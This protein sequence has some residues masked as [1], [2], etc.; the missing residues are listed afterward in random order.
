[1]DGKRNR[2]PFRLSL[3]LVVLTIA[4]YWGVWAN[5]F[6][7]WDDQ[8]YVYENP[9]V[10]SGLSW[11]NFVWAWTTS[12]CSNWH[13]LTWLSLMLDASLFGRGPAGFHVTNLALH[14]ANVVLLF[15][16]LRQFTEEVRISACAAAMFAVHPGHVESVAWIS[17][18][19]DVLC[20]F[21]G[22]LALRAYGQFAEKLKLRFYFGSLTAFA[23]SLLAKPMLVTFPF[24][25]ILLDHWPLK[26]LLYVG[27]SDSTILPPNGSTTAVST[28]G[29][30]DNRRFPRLLAEK[31]PFFLLSALSCLIT[32]QVQQ[33]GG[34]VES[35]LALQFRLANAVIAYGNYV[36]CVLIPAD[37]SV[38][39]PHARTSISWLPLVGSLSGLAL[40][41]RP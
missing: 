30:L 1:M 14:V 32:Y 21:F 24:L 6:V 34:A 40:I 26:R 38:F 22:L 9:H 33:A 35:H 18:R 16:V 39:Y 31:L 36:S 41:S 19:K 20:F 15:S 27:E 8:Q 5:G 13:P 23:A 4:A 25:L 11:T 2:E 12:A 17:E 29:S 7:N 10:I 3:G 28:I 37:F